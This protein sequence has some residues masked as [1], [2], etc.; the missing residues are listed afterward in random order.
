MNESGDNEADVLFKLLQDFSTENMVKLRRKLAS[1]PEHVT[2]LFIE[3]GG[4]DQIFLKL[5]SEGQKVTGEE[6]SSVAQCVIEGLR[7]LKALMRNTF[8]LDHV[9]IGGYSAHFAS[10]KL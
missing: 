10:C 3:K 5:S 7:V 1:T 6:M 9:A 4:A 8:G 2:K